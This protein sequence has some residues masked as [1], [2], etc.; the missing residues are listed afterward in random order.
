MQRYYIVILIV[1]TVAIGFM[2]LRDDDSSLPSLQDES[3]AKT[4]QPSHQS[5]GASQPSGDNKWWQQKNNSQPTQ[6]SK[7]SGTK[8]DHEAQPPVALQKDITP[9]QWNATI[10]QDEPPEQ[11]VPDDLTGDRFE[12]PQDYSEE[13]GNLPPPPYTDSAE[14]SQIDESPEMQ[15]SIP[16]AAAEDMTLGEP[17]SIPMQP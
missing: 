11:L 8:S 10:P 16:D 6:T 14:L 7:S 12:A 3:K 2:Y 13:L 1:V 9:E 4:E 5:L 15:A 17:D